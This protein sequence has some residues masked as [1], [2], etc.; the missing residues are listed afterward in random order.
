MSLKSKGINAERDL[1][2][3]FWENGWSACRI[4]GS[5]CTKYPS[6]DVVAGNNVRRLAIE[7]KVTKDI[8]QYFE[9]KQINDLN[10]F[11]RMFGA[12]PWV[13]VKFNNVN[14]FFLTID[15]LEETEKGHSISL[16]DAKTKGFMFEEMIKK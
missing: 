3:M 5:G 9:K 7:C 11:A 16:S 1:I 8:R 6:P 12:E 2:H 14:W 13:A 10:L 15:D 4:A